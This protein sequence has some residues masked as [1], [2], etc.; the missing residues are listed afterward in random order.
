LSKIKIGDCRFYIEFVRRGARSECVW[1]CV[2]VET[3]GTPYYRS[4]SH[5]LCLKAPL[6]ANKRSPGAH[7]PR[8][9]ACPNRLGVARE[10]GS[11]K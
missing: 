6:G 4:S 1:S 10:R 11:S 2:G 7:A 8:D 3:P 9:L 5:T